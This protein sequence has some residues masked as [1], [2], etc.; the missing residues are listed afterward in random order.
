[1]AIKIWLDGIIQRW[2]YA[3]LG[4]A[5]VASLLLGAFGLTW[6]TIL[7]T[8][9]GFPPALIEGQLAFDP[10]AYHAWYAVLLE[11]GTLPLY[12]RTQLVDYL[13]IAGLVSTLFFLHLLI[14]KA[15]P[16]VRW[17]NLA[18]ILAILAPAI[19]L[20]DA[21]ENMVT[22]TMLSNPTDFAP[23]L[24]YLVSMLS[25][26]KWGWALIGCPLI[27]IQLVALVWMRLRRPEV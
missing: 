4:A 10:N 8:K 25:A 15:Q 13:Y 12:V 17:S 14:A 11:K 9:S 22:L 2:S 5:L 7:Y 21:I 20:S 23:W 26:I 27:C 6:A 1:M 18:L 3:K 16:S 24:A 19:A